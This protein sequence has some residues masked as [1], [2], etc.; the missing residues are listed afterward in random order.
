MTI[1]KACSSV[2]HS[3]CCAT[4][5]QNSSSYNNSIKV[6]QQIVDKCHQL[7]TTPVPKTFLKPEEEQSVLDIG[8]QI[9]Q[10]QKDLE[11]A[12]KD[13]PTYDLPDIYK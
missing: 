10:Y 4:N 11:A 2:V 7:A 12:K 3:C 8:K 5:L 13:V 6:A 1:S 9:A